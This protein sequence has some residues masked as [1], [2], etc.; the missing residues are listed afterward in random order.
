MKNSFAIHIV[1]D[2]PLKQLFEY[3]KLIFMSDTTLLQ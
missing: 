3:N 1:S 2:I